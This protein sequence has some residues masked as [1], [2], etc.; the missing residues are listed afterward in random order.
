MAESGLWYFAH[1]YSA[2]TPD[3]RY[4]LAAEEANFRL[5][6]LRAA[7]LL[8]AGWNIYAPICHTHPIHMAYA[9]FLAREEHQ[10]WYRLDN[11]FIEHANFTG[12]ILADGWAGSIGCCNEKARFGLLGRQVR[13]FFDP[14]E[15]S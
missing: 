11:A 1:P 4:C 10:M 13:Y 12:I 14:C 15:V 5:C 6:C 2:K 7:R 8:D 9:P 3:G